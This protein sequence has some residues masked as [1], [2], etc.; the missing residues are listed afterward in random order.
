MSAHRSAAAPLAGAVA[1]P[2]F[3][4]HPVRTGA[5]ALVDVLATLGAAALASV[6]LGAGIALAAWAWARLRS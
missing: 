1:V 2:W 3:V 4:H 5:G 6:A